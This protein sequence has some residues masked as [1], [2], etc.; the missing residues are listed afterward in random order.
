MGRKNIP[1]VQAP[2][3]CAE[4]ILQDT[5]EDNVDHKSAGHLAS[6]GFPDM[7]G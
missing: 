2:G 7:C 5:K 4:C 3:F 6:V 1:L